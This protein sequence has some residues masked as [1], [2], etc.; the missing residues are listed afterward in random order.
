MTVI[1]A[2]ERVTLE[3]NLGLKALGEENTTFEP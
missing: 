2:D 1:Q 3:H